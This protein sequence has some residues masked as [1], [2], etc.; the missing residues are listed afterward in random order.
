MTEEKI[1][2]I[3]YDETGFIPADNKVKAI[4]A[5]VNF[6][7]EEFKASVISDYDENRNLFLFRLDDIAEKLKVK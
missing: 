1:R 3:Y 5:I 2:D 4:T 6:T 7:I